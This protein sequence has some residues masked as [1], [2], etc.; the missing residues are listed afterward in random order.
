MS[1]KIIVVVPIYDCNDEYKNRI[2]SINHAKLLHEE[3]KSLTNDKFI[4]GI[5]NY[6]N[7]FINLKDSYEDSIKAINNSKDKEIAHIMDVS[8][9]IN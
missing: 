1:N 4:I 6:Y 3:I 9:N 5:G 8:Y 7:K 2:E